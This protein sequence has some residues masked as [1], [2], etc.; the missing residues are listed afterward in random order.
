MT[1]KSFLIQLCLRTLVSFPYV[2]RT[3]VEIGEVGKTRGIH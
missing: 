1:N 2:F 3:C